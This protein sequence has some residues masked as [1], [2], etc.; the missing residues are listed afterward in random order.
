MISVNCVFRMGRTIAEAIMAK[1]SKAEAVRTRK[2]IL[3][4]ILRMRF[5]QLPGE[6]VTAV[7]SRKG[8]KQLDDWLERFATAETLDE[9]GIEV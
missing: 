1:A 9:I 7:Q 5:P 2:Q 6:V 3:L 8:V 4:W